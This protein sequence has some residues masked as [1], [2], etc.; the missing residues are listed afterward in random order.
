[1]SFLQ[2]VRREMRGSLRKLVFMSGIGGISS[3]AILAA[4]NAG[5]QAVDESHRPSLWAATLFVISLFLFIK[6]Q[7]Y[8]TITVTAEIEAIIHKTPRAPY[9]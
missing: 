1:M 2:L 6:T 5:A 7:T 4:I 3:A 8:V 9:G